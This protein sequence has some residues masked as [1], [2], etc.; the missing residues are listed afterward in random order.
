MTG[1]QTCALPI[2]N[3]IAELPAA[4]PDPEPDLPDYVPAEWLPDDDTTTSFPW[5]LP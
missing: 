3:P 1:V 2:W 4:E 5:N